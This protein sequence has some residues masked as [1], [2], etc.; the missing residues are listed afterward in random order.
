MSDDSESATARQMADRRRMLSN[1]RVI[2]HWEIENK[3]CYTRTTTATVHE[4]NKYKIEIYRFI[5]VN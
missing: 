3:C 2:L 4:Q 1:G 5:N